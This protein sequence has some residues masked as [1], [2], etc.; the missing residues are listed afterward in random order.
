MVVFLFPLLT[1]LFHKVLIL[2]CAVQLQINGGS[3]NDNIWTLLFCLYL[4]NLLE[5]NS[6]LTGDPR[7]TEIAND[8]SPSCCIQGHQ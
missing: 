6:R 7:S 5:F 1:L 2:I 3:V 4:C 8:N